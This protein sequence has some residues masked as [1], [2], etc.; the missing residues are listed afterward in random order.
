MQVTPSV[1]QIIQ[2][3]DQPLKIADAIGI[4]VGKRLNVK[5]V[6]DSVFEPQ[7][8]GGAAGTAVPHLT[9]AGPPGFNS[10]GL[11]TTVASG[12]TVILSDHGRPC[13]GKGLASTPPMF[14]CPLPPYRGSIAVQDLLPETA[15]RRADSIV[16]MRQ[17]SE[18]TDEQKHV[19]RRAAL[20][21]KTNHAAGHIVAVDPFEAGCI[22][23]QFVQRGLAAH[24]R[25]QIAHP[26][27]QAADAGAERAGAT[28][29]S[30]S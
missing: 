18:V 3:L 5:F 24:Q 22:R 27:L 12:G 1:L 19:F 28:R 15:G 20:A 17:R 14:P 25:I 23:I 29:G 26:S 30:A 10:I 2:L 16:M 8:I 6:D 7:G 4:A 13:M 11:N 21:Q 9:H